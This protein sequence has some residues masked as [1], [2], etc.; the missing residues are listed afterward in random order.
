MYVYNKQCWVGSLI[1][2]HL[3]LL[4]DF[5]PYKV[6]LQQLFL[7]LSQIFT[8]LTKPGLAHCRSQVYNF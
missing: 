2:H 8:L 1:D 4:W 7:S 5:G 3:L 6:K